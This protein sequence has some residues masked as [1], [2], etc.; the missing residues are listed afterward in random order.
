MQKKNYGNFSKHLNKIILKQGKPNLFTLK[1][2]FI[3]KAFVFSLKNR[4]PHTDLLQLLDQRN[5]IPGAFL[6]PLHL[7]SHVIAK[8]NSRNLNSD[9]AF[10]I[11][12]HFWPLS[13]LARGR[14]V[15]LTTTITKEYEKISRVA[16]IF[17]IILMDRHKNV[18][19]TRSD[20]II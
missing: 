4:Q 2:V 6:R 8:R 10:F 12:I 18:L 9:A 15:V 13:F 7:Q 19:H 20:L 14:R 3:A 16:Q 1:H 5:G 17:M 11:S